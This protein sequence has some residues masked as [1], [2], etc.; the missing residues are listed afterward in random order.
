MYSPDVDCP[1]CNKLFY[2]E[3][4]K[5]PF[6]MK[7]GERINAICPECNRIIELECFKQVTTI[8]YSYEVD[9]DEIYEGR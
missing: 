8:Y 5:L 6:E 4:F 3:D 9:E 7:E 1:Y 2:I